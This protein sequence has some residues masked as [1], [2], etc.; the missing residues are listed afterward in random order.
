MMY[1]ALPVNM[2]PA[3]PGQT[4]MVYRPMPMYAYPYAAPSV[5]QEREASSNENAYRIALL[6]FLPLFALWDL[7]A[8]YCNFGTMLDFFGLGDVKLI[9]V[10]VLFFVTALLK[11]FSMV[12]GAMTLASPRS[13]Y[14]YGFEVVQ[15]ISILIS[16]A[17]FIYSAAISL[18]QLLPGTFVGIFID[19]VLHIGTAGLS[20]LLWKETPRAQFAFV[21]VPQRP[22]VF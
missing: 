7:L 19:Y 11:L 18:T 4:P 22:R 1:P 3:K 9:I 20:A 16:T 17:T 10:A 14:L 12:V 15:I 13:S 5:P 2:E 8:L 21:M 6:V